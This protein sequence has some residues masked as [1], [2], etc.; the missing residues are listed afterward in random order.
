MLH[1]R[2]AALKLLPPSELKLFDAARSDA[3]KRLDGTRARANLARVRQLGAK[4]RA[5]KPRTGRVVEK[6][7][8]FTELEV[9][10]QRRLE[11]L[12]AMQERLKAQADRVTGAPPRRAGRK[13]RRGGTPSARKA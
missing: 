8:I 12:R 6:A 4:Y 11:H 7:E 3:L 5:A 13:A 10:F 9:R 2:N 1:N